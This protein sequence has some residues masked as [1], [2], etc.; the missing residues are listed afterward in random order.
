MARNKW[1]LLCSLLLTALPVLGSC[2]VTDLQLR[3][4]ALTTASR[5]VVTTGLTVLQ[6]AIQQNQGQ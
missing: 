5:A 6:A 1:T 2:G 3:D 4:F